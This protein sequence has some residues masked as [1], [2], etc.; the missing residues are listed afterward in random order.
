MVYSNNG[1]L[2]RMNAPFRESLG[3][4]GKKGG[5]FTNSLIQRFSGMKLSIPLDELEWRPGMIVRGVKEV[6]FLYK[7]TIKKNTALCS[8]CFVFV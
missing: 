3:F 4:A 5:I 8:F 1:L 7:H 6:P 2:Y